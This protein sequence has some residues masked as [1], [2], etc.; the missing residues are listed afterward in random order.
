[1]KTK[2]HK[3]QRAL[4]PVWEHEQQRIYQGDVVEVLKKLPEESVQ[5]CI[6]SP[7]YWGL[8]TYLSNEHAD[9]K[10]EIGAEKTPAEYVAKMVG[11]C[12]EIRRVLR[13]DGVFFI[14]IGD[15]YAAN[16]S[17]QR[18]EGGG[19]FKENGRDR[20]KYPPPGLKA[21]NLIGIPWRVALALQADGWI[22]RQA[23][24]WIKRSC[25]PE[26]VTDRPTNALEYIF[27]L[28]KSSKYYF[29]MDA[30]KKAKPEARLDRFKRGVSPNHKLVAGAP[31]Q[32]PHSMSQPRAYDVEWQAEATRNFRNSDLWFESIAQPFSLCGVGEELVGLDVTSESCRASHFATFPQNLVR[33]LILLGTSQE[34]CCPTCK[35]PWVRIVKKNRQPTRPADDS[36][37]MDVYKRRKISQCKQTAP[38]LKTTLGS[39][40]GNRDPQ[41][42]VTGTETIGWEPACSCRRAYPIPC[43]VLDVFLGSGTTLQVALSL[44]RAGIGIELSPEYIKIAQERILLPMGKTMAKAREGLSFFDGEE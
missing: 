30:V 39:I 13:K 11:V 23:M 25:M 2:K 19:G 41:R 17:S 33:P 29:D 3:R 24:P 26:G 38:G 5:C 31:G 18:K 6:T 28:T 40:V 27:M 21:K 1:V 20:I 9:K 4:L 36:K 37:V 12:W 32:T 10:Y 15:T 43:T 8:R 14:N 22:L 16:W 44:G 42:H 35:K 7:P 34:G